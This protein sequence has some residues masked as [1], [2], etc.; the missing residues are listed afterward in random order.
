MINYMNLRIFVGYGEFETYKDDMYSVQN[1]GNLNGNPN[2]SMH[3]FESQV[4]PDSIRFG[5]N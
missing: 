4:Q 2:L 3:Y 5:F 1:L